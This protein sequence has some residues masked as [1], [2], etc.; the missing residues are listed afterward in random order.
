MIHND[1][2]FYKNNELEVDTKRFI[3]YIQYIPTECM[4]GENEWQ[5]IN[6]RKKPST[7]S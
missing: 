4:K 7:K 1:K 5:E 6:I 3:G 2:E